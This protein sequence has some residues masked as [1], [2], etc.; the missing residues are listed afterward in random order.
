LRDRVADKLNENLISDAR[1][2]LQ[3][4]GRRHR[5]AHFVTSWFTRIQYA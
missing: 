5:F 2:S 1:F 4:S 3:R